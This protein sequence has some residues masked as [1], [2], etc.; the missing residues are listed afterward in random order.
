MVC[1]GVCDSTNKAAL[2]CPGCVND[3]LLFERRKMLVELSE[4][5][6]ALL[7]SLNGLIA[8]KQPH[9]A[10]E[11]R[12]QQ[13]AVSAAQARERAR[14]A[15][16]ALEAGEAEG[17]RSLGRAGAGSCEG[18]G[19]TICNLKLPDSASVS[20][21]MLQQP[22]ATSSALGY[23]LLLQELLSTYLGGP[24]LHEGSFQ[25]SGAACLPR[26]LPCRTPARVLNEPYTS[27][28]HRRPTG[29]RELGGR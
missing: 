25:A 26:S 18:L 11:V 3:T 6:E 9:V 20:S 14:Q 4:R 5:R 2:V 24:L 28:L 13:L 8:Q 29:P 15:E 16:R 23:L 1:C 17:G 22:E 21:L 10:L 19:V 7:Q 12:R 27:A